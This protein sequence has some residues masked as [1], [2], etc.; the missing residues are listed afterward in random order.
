[1]KFLALLAGAALLAS[2]VLANSFTNG[3]FET[4]TN[5][6]GQLGYNTNATGWTTSGYNFV[7]ASGT[8]DTTGS[9]GVYGRLSLWGPNNGAANGFPASSPQGGNF[10][11][12]DG[13][14]GTAPISQ[15]ITGLKVGRTY[16]IGYDYAFAQQAGFSGDTIQHWSSSFGGTSVTTADYALPNHGFSGWMH[17]SYTSVATSTSETLSFLAY[18]NLPVPPFAL[19]DGVTVS[20][21]VPEPATWGLF[22][23]GFGVVGA[24]A[25]RRR[26]TAVAA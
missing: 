26:T 12:A 5:G 3:G 10:V 25:R 18:G 9:S 6:T 16:T 21:E 19:L 20:G 15:V 13:D 24:M 7:F 17:T 22:L 11:G 14:F 8:G 4:L 2:P 1:M 23:A